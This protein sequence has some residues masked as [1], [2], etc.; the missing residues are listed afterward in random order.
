MG[1]AHGS[2]V[3]ALE[4]QVACLGHGL[5]QVLG[6]CGNGRGAVQ[7]LSAYVPVAVHSS[8]AMPSSQQTHPHTSPAQGQEK[9]V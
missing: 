9:N 7:A 1:P 6:F 3:T 2:R 5:R 4:I 8:P